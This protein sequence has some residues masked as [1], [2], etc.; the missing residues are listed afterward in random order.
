V[1]HRSFFFASVRRSLFTGR[2]TQRQVDGLER[3]GCGGSV[4]AQETT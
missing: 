4:G 1:I 2:L 3:S